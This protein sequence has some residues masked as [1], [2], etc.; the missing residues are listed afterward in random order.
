MHK[1]SDNTKIN[2]YILRNGSGFAMGRSKW[3][4]SGA[5][6]VAGFVGLGL[7]G[8]GADAQEVSGADAAILEQLAPIAARDSEVDEARSVE[9]WLPS[10]H[11]LEDPGLT[12]GF[13][14]L[15][16]VH[17][18]QGGEERFRDVICLGDAALEEPVEYCYRWAHYSDMPVFED[19]SAVKI[20][21]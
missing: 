18:E 7:A 3:V 8:C 11:P 1:D 16:R 15:C 10:E 20:Y 13:R 17:Y 9:C 4:R 5:V 21:L 2:Y 19:S 12:E 6:L 14:I